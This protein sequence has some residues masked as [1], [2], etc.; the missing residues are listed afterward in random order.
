VV[1]IVA[2]EN[3][4]AA[5]AVKDIK[6]FNC[7]AVSKIGTNFC[8]DCGENLAGKNENATREPIVAVQD[9]KCLQ[10]KT[11]NEIGTKFCQQCGEQLGIKNTHGINI[12]HKVEHHQPKVDVVIDKPVV[13]E[14][15]V[16]EQKACPICTVLCEAR[17]NFCPTCNHRF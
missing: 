16:D 2:E 15:K 11:V 17:I 12:N 10:C 6:C 4:N 13:A 7:N 8:D 3:A 9:N 5:A 14:V 1:K